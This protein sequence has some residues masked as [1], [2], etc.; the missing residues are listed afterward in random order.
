[1]QLSV[2]CIVSLSLT[3]A[4]FHTCLLSLLLISVKQLELHLIGFF[5]P[6]S[7]SCIHHQSYVFKTLLESHQQLSV[8][9]HDT[10]T[11]QSSVI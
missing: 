8:W 7:P 10:A 5:L 1:M 2:A 3:E 4:Q 9:L 6:S 11:V